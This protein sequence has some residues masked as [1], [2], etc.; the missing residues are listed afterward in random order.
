MSEVREYC[1]GP[2]RENHSGVD[3][4]TTQKKRT[5]VPAWVDVIDNGFNELANNS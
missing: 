5:V 2:P 4:H 1:S 3:R